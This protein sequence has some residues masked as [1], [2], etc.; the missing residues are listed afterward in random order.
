MKRFRCSFLAIALLSFV[1]DASRALAQEAPRIR[2]VVY[3]RKHGLA[4]TMDVLKP[5][6]PN[7]VGLLYMVSGGFTSDI[8]F[9]DSV[10]KLE[11]FKPFLDK[12]QTIFFVCHSSQPKFTVGEIVPDIHR[13]ARYIRT[14]AKT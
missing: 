13:A 3:G 9:V 2:D 4:L 1:A 8:A 5:A 10:F 7:G 11:T 14:N 12:G 6:K